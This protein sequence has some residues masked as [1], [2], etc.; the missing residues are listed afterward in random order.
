MN[1]LYARNWSKHHSREFCRHLVIAVT[2]LLSP[3]LASAV[4]IAPSRHSVGAKAPNAY[5]PYV[6]S[7]SLTETSP[8]ITRLVFSVHSSGFDALQYFE[9]ARTAAAAKDVIPE[10][11][12]VAPQFFEQTAIPGD[13]P[14]GMLFWRVSPFRGSSRGGVG[15]D[16]TPVGISSFDVID[17]WLT[18][19]TEPKRFP[20]L[21]D[22]VLVGHSGG[23]QLVQR[24]AMVGKFEPS[25]GMA[26][27]FVVSAP[28]SY[29]YPSGERFNIR[30]E[31]FVVPGNSV[32]AECPN[33]NDWGYGLESPYGYFSKVRPEL[34]TERYAKRNVF[35]LCGS[36]D[37]DPNDAS[38]GKSCGAMM[39][40][41]HRLER[42]QVFEA[43]L[44]SKYGKSIKATHRFSVVRGMGHY[45]RGTMT[46]Q[47]GLEALFSPIR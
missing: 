28:S 29:A 31:S 7:H 8:K 24:Y 25:T 20:N 35:Y 22:V 1:L 26:I 13:I 34:I 46:S 43:F 41:R 18:T 39:Q 21:T 47:Q 17:D 37:N 16:A 30:S 36:K 45:G 3:S 32:I 27:R 40:G 12:I 19:L 11:L 5:V 44:E 14:D 9:N 4:E 10:T 23:G 42:M 6:A 2:L 15:P 33:Y 38:I